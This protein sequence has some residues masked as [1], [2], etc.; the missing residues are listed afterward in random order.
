M[1]LS[2]VDLLAEYCESFLDDDTKKR[3]DQIAARQTNEFGV[4]QFGLDAQTLRAITPIMCWFYRHYFRVE[5]FGAEH[6]PK[7]R[8][9]VISNHSG[10]L[11]FD[12][13]MIAMAF[14]LEAKFPRL[15]R[16][17]AERWTAEIPFISTLLPRMGQV[18]GSPSTCKTLL[19]HDEGVIVFP[20][21][22]RGI[23]KLFSERYQLTS[24]GTGFMRIALASKAPIIPVAVIGAEEQAPAVANLGTWA[25]SLGIPA[26]PV[27]FPQLIPWPLPVKYR[28]YIGEP[29]NFSGD[30]TEDDDDI[31]L[32]VLE[33]KN[34][35]QEMINHGLRERKHIFF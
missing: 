9:M 12:G 5:T 28:I 18:V 3:I 11:P 33:T 26:L 19:S 20:E 24:F 22:V 32:M 25:K 7:G 8:M 27:I 10:Q 29:L 14:L 30:G 31:A 2:F 16:G 34:R 17:M 13:A 23:S 15:L 21:G 4:D 1:A 6:I 35:V